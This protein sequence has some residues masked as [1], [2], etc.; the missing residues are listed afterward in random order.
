M[1]DRNSNGTFKKGHTGNKGGRPK[2]VA[3]LVKEL[4]NDYVDYINILDGWARDENLTEEF[5]RKCIYDILNRSMGMPTQHQI[6]EAKHDITIEG[7][8]EL[9]DDM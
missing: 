1:S 4:S 6:T 5:R 7:P 9:V 8:K 2:G 3:A